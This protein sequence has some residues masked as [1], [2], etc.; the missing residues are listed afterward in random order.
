[1]SVVLA[2]QE[3]ET[4]TAR[5]A[6]PRSF[7]ATLRR[8]WFHRYVYALMLPGLVYY[9][10]FHYVPMWGIVVAF[11]DFRPWN[12]LL[13]S[14]WVGF[15]NFAQFFH[16]PYFWRLVRNT[17][18]ISGLNLV[19][20]F[21]AP[22]GLALLINE[23]RPAWYKRT[24]QTVSY[25]PHFVSWIVVGGL[26]IYLFSVNVGFVN[27][28]LGSLGL[29]AARVLGNA[30]AFLPLVVGSGIWKEVGWGAIIYLAAIAGISPELYEAATVDGANR[31]QRVLY[32]TLPSLVPV[33]VVLLILQVGHILDVNFL[34]ILILIGSDAS[35]YEVGDV[36]ETWVYRTGFFQQQFSLA[37]AIGLLKG[38]LGLGL[39]W[40]ANRV[41]KRLTDSGLW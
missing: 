32:V 21:P 6:A 36:I 25:Y 29:P 5:R 4:K 9:L 40:G 34:Q 27:M 1:M 11:Q 7:W 17:L 15:D 22:L 41:T 26:L 28:V 35:L 37:A 39:V 23:V 19:F 18:V 38:V 30:N 24:I 12:G 16:G 20:V 2:T 8:V 10:A 33:A 13:N 14:P 31:W 3:I